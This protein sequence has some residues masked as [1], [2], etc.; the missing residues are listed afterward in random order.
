MLVKVLLMVV[1]LVLDNDSPV[2]L[3]LEEANQ[4][5]VELMLDVRPIFKVDPLHIVEVL[6]LVTI[7]V[8]KTVTVTV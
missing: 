4:L 6:V 3:L 8:A 7:G 1:E 2:T 5:K